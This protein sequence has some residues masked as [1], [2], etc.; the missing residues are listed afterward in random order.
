[1]ML[2]GLYGNIYSCFCSQV[3]S[4][5][6]NQCSPQRSVLL[7][8]TFSPV[9]M[10]PEDNI[11]LRRMG[12][13]WKM[14]GA[15]RKRSLFYSGFKQRPQGF[16]KA[17]QKYLRSNHSKIKFNYSLLLRAPTLFIFLSPSSITLFRS[18]NGRLGTCLCVCVMR[19]V[20]WFP[21]VPSKPPHNGPII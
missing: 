14:K 15:P 8:A 1:M 4:R 21:S 11:D 20:C 18:P 16:R 19:A 3:P 10:K 5:K 12:R 2:S 7:R 13:N 6:Q 9:S 17:S